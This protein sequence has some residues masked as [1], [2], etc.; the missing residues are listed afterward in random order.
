MPYSRRPSAD[1][2]SSIDGV[3]TGVHGTPLAEAMLTVVDRTGRELARSRSGRHGGCRLPVPGPGDYLVVAAA[4]GHQPRALS[5]TV[6]ERRTELSLCLTTS[7]SIAG[8]VQ[9]DTLCMP[10]AD[11]L[12]LLVDASGSVVGS[13]MTSADGAYS[14]P[15]VRPASYTLA[16]AHHQHTPVAR[17]VMVT[18]E[19]QPT[20]VDVALSY[21]LLQLDGTARDRHGVPVVGARVTLTDRGLI[22]REVHTDAAGRYHFQSLP[23]GQYR[24][25]AVGPLSEWVELEVTLHRDRHRLDLWLDGPQDQLGYEPS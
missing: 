25:S 4:P 19:C 15:S 20:A 23:I 1:G 24:L 2:R 5:V 13:R 6:V 3:I 12:V 22:A 18:A 21:R 10:L 7:S 16:V 11:A 14:L 17:E 9:D 8:I